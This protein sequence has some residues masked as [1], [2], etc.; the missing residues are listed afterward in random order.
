[1]AYSR[2]RRG[3]RK[4]NGRGDRARGSIMPNIAQA[5]PAT[6]WGADWECSSEKRSKGTMSKGTMS[7]I[8]LV[9]RP[10][11][12]SG[13][14]IGSVPSDHERWSAM[15]AG[16]MKWSARLS[17]RQRLSRSDAIAFFVTRRNSGWTLHQMRLRGRSELCSFPVDLHVRDLGPAA[18]TKSPNV[19]QELRELA[20][21]DCMR[22]VQ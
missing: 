22:D 17:R 13:A 8:A 10:P 1:M 7:E 12:A 16:G 2:I 9:D 19:R 14:Q 20:D 15:R 11:N 5:G 3:T 21:F 4:A 6:G 18:P